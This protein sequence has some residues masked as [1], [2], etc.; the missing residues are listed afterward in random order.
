MRY[1][2]LSYDSHRSNSENILELQPVNKHNKK[3]SNNAMTQLMARLM[4]QFNTPNEVLTISKTFKN[5]S[6]LFIV[7]SES[8][9]LNQGC[10]GLKCF[11]DEFLPFS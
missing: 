4:A 9:D 1:I 8:Y 10:W 6:K 5:F 7:C 2:I 3:Q 11:L